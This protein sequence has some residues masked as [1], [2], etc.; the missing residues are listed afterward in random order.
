MEVRKEDGRVYAYLVYRHPEGGR[1]TPR[2]C[3]V[4]A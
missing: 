1:K 4:K 3:T 2:K